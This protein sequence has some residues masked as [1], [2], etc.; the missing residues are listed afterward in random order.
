[1]NF[2]GLL[3]LKSKQNVELARHNKF[4]G[5][6]EFSMKT[7]SAVSTGFSFLA[8]GKNLAAETPIGVPAMNLQ[9]GDAIPIPGFPGYLVN[10]EGN[11]FSKLRRGRTGG[12]AGDIQRE[13]RPSINEQ[14]Y[15]RVVLFVG[16]RA[17]TEFVHALV[18]LAFVGP[19]PAGLHICHYDGNSGNNTL[20]N[21]RYDTPANNYLD[22]LRLGVAVRGPNHPL[23]KLDAEKVIEMRRRRAA[24]EKDKDLALAFGVSRSLCSEVGRGLHWSWVTMPESRAAL[25]RALPSTEKGAN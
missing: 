15:K 14:G 7:V 3:G 23:A 17:H 2:P 12:E 5:N 9:I 8:G 22:S 6:D 4:N 19:R 16:R 11:I 10:S 20:K 25:S 13:L 21:L 1:M 24:G 18:L